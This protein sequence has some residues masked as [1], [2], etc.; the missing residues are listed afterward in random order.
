MSPTPDPAVT[1]DLLA[2]D[3]RIF[4]LRRGHRFSTDDL[5]C[6]HAASHAR[7]DGLRLLDLGAGLGSV[8]LLTLRRMPP[9]AHLVMVEAQ[10]VSHE[11][12]RRT[13]EHNRLTSRVEARLGDLRDPS[14]V[15]EQAAF[16][17]VTC[18]PPYIPP[19]RGLV[20]PVAQRAAARIELR[21]NLYDYLATARR[22][23]A[24]EGR[25]VIV[26]AGRDPR[27][28]D[29]VLKN[30]LALVS[31]RPVL[32]REGR[33][34]T[35]QILVAAHTSEAPPERLPP[36]VVR[37]GDGRWS[38]EMLAIRREMGALLPLDDPP[39]TERL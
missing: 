3:W 36:L 20:S 17:L 30:G 37:D 6:A 32:F 9:E 29:A 21:G 13:V 5:L 7:P 25:V 34:P 11:L 22:A 15:P 23:L 39:S 26:F 2:W 16:D 1:L 28:E 35:I 27:G 19:G 14:V 18:S 10:D 8:G 33:P 12:A 4:Q 31:Q 24:P 38:H